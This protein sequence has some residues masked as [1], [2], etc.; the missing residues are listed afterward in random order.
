MRITEPATTVIYPAFLLM[1]DSNAAM[2]NI[3]T[4]MYWYIQTPFAA[5]SAL[6]IV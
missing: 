4:A 6:I 2:P 5:I 1:T 3:I